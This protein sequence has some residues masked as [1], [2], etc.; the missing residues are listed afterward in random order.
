MVARKFGVTSVNI[1]VTSVCVHGRA[2]RAPTTHTGDYIIPH[3]G[4]EARPLHQFTE[5]LTQICLNLIKLFIY[6]LSIYGV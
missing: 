3:T 5:N 4:I 6:N 2:M 1:D